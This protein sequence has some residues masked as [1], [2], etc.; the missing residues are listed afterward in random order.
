[1][2]HVCQHPTLKNRRISKIHSYLCPCQDN[3]PRD[4]NQQND[5]RFD[6]PVDKSGEQLRSIS[7]GLSKCRQIMAYL[8]FIAAELPVAECQTLQSNGELDITATHNVLNFELRE[9]GVETKLLDDAS[10]L[11][12]SKP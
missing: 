5:L 7:I 10:V 12:R 2:Q 3:L 8:R 9:L 6:H 4:E 1:M 11:S